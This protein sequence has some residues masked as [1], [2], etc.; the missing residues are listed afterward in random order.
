MIASQWRAKSARLYSDAMKYLLPIAGVSFLLVLTSSPEVSA[1]TSDTISSAGMRSVTPA[2]FL[3]LG[4][5]QDSEH[6][7]DETASN[8]QE[9]P[10]DHAENNGERTQHEAAGGGSEDAGGHGEPDLGQR[11]AAELAVQAPPAW[12][13]KVVWGAGLLFILAATLGSA[14]IVLK[15]PEPPDP[16]DDHGHH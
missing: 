8:S 12:Y 5:L 3:A 13:G 4:L 7:A 15:G 11:R 10:A 9:V 6:A 2:T 14:A 1:R 16:A